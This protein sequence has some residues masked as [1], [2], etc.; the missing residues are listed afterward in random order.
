MYM[1]TFLHFKP[2]PAVFISESNTE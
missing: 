1:F 2:L